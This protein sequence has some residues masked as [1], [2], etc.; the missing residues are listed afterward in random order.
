MVASLGSIEMFSKSVVFACS[1][2]EKKSDFFCYHSALSKTNWISVFT[3]AGPPRGQLRYLVFE[4]FSSSD[5]LIGP[6]MW[7][8]CKFRRKRSNLT[9][10]TQRF[11][12]GVR[13]HKKRF[14]YFSTAALV[15]MLD[16]QV[17][18]RYLLSTSAQCSNGKV[19]SSPKDITFFF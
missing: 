6:V 2:E 5:E 7:H 17:P 9:K 4:I 19:N 18:R 1:V 3:T 13:R 10:N 8:L 16:W 15:L 12:Q 11:L 14:S